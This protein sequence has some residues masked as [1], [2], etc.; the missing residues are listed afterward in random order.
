MQVMMMLGSS[1]EVRWHDVLVLVRLTPRRGQSI[2]QSCLSLTFL[3]CHVIGILML[4]AWCRVRS[5]I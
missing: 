3:I 5:S 4:H 2:W 1:I